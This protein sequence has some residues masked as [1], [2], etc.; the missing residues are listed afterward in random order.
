MLSRQSGQ[1]SLQAAGSH[2]WALTH[3]ILIS[4]GSSSGEQAAAA[5]VWDRQRTMRQA[6][7]CSTWVVSYYEDQLVQM[8]VGWIYMFTHMGY[9]T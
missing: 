3:F 1:R 4:F 8:S 7:G 6:M 5:G 9:I 2:G